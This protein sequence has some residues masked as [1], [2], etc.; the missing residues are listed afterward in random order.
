MKKREI[1]TKEEAREYAI[2][3]QSWVSK[4]KSIYYS[5]LAEW[6]DIFW[7]LGKKFHLIREFKENG[8]I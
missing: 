3:W 4:K 6:N 2:E 5:E 7:K 8:I 1:K